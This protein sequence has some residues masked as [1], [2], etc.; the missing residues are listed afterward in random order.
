MV[1]IIVIAL[2]IIALGFVLFGI[3]ACRQAGQWDDEAGY[4]RG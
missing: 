1:T 4:P 2:A 3:A